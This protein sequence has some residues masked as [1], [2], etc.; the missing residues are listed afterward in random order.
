[1]SDMA[2]IRGRLPTLKPHQ[3][4]DMLEK[5]RITK[6]LHVVEEELQLVTRQLRESQ[7]SQQVSYPAPSGS[8]AYIVVDITV[9][10]FGRK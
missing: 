3:E 5:S 2:G 4:E 8:T 1:M 6:R 10:N 7:Q 9:E